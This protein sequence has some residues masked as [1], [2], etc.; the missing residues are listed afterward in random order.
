[1]HKYPIGSTWRQHGIVRVP[2]NAASRNDVAVIAEIMRF[3]RNQS[4]SIVYDAVGSAAVLNHH[5]DSQLDVTETRRRH[6][7]II[8]AVFYRDLNAAVI[9]QKARLRLVLIVLLEDTAQ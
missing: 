2:Y 3:A 4:N 8:Y 6:F 5:A 9:A 7:A 1:M